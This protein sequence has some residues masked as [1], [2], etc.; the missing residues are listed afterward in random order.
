MADGPMTNPIPQKDGKNNHP[1]KDGAPNPP[2]K[3]YIPGKPAFGGAKKPA[4]N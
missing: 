1:L 3:T 2:S 4:G